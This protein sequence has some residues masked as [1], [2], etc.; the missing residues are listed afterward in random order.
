MRKRREA[1][2]ELER[3]VKAPHKVVVVHYS[4]ESF[5]ER[6]NGFSPRVTSI[7]V[8]HFGSEQTKSFGIVLEAEKAGIEAESIESQYDELERRFIEEF[9]KYITTDCR[10]LKIMHW[11]MRSVQFGFPAIAHRL[12]VLGGVPPHI[13]DDRLVD[14]AALLPQIYGSGYVAHP[15]MENLFKENGLTLKDFLTGKQEAAAFDGREFFKLHLSTLRKVNNI[16]SVVHLASDELLKTSGR[17]RGWL[18][19]AEMVDLAK[20][21]WLIACFSVLGVVLAF[22]R[23]V[24]WF[25]SVFS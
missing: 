24:A 12:T 9:Y 15:H 10:D 2:S 20:S 7:A 3:I 4:C 11:H 18:Y 17:G 25:V 23:G 21:H 22:G 6:P 5:Y 14:V 13:P 19:V 16:A 1:R 8:R